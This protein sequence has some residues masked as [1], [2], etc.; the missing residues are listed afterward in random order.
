L[1][2]EQNH[3]CDVT[4]GCSQM[5][6]ILPTVC[7]F[8]LKQSKWPSLFAAHPPL[9]KP[10]VGACSPPRRKPGPSVGPEEW[11]L[12]KIKSGNPTGLKLRGTTTSNHL[13]KFTLKLKTR[14]SERWRFADL[15]GPKRNRN[16]F[17]E[18]TFLHL[19][20]PRGTR[21]GGRCYESAVRPYIGTGMSKSIGISCNGDD[22]GSV[23]PKRR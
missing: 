12:A 7:Y 3:G 6:F 15:N 9:A 5:P 19:G 10:R 13:V 2:K 1:E 4:V 18:V 8:Y 14:R 17:H 20:P 11:D 16:R 23:I 21:E 22:T